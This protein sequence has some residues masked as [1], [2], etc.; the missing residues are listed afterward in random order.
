MSSIIDRLEQFMNS[1]GINNNQLTV[2]A[3]LSIG[4]IGSAR[5]KRTGLHSDNLEKIL[6]ACPELNPAWLITGK[7]EMLQY[8]YDRKKDDNISVTE[9]PGEEYRLLV[10][11]FRK[12]ISILREQLAEAKKDRE[13]L[14]KMISKNYPFK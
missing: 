7:E 14:R 4:L 2:K 9:D 11:D 6:H 1:Q 3:G 5:K 12:T 8:G 10:K 13:L